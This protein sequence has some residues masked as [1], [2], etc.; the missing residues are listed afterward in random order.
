MPCCGGGGW[1]LTAGVRRM[2]VGIAMRMM[3]VMAGMIVMRRQ[4]GGDGL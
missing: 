3:M 1:R 2:V 4:H